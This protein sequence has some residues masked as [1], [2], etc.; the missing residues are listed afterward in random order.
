MWYRL[1]KIDHKGEKPQHHL[2]MGYPRLSKV[3]PAQTQGKNDVADPELALHGADQD[4]LRSLQHQQAVFMAA[5][6]NR[7]THSLAPCSQGRT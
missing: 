6:L 7:R 4:L 5:E 3:P 1:R 2:G